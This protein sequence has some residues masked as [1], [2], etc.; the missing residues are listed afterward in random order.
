MLEELGEEP[1]TRLLSLFS[2][3][4]NPDVENFLKQK[5]IAFEKTHNARTRLILDEQGSILAYF[6]VS[7]KELVLE[8]AALNKSQVKRLDGFNKNAE[9]IRA[10][11]IGQ[12]GK[13]FSV[14][15]NRITLADIL[16]EIYSIIHDARELVGGR[17]IILECENNPA[18]IQLYRDHGFT[19]IETTDDDKTELRTMYIHI[20]NQ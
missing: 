17:V 16:A 9:R 15:N 20:A 1:T 13:N 3:P 18:L 10:F 6:S 11:L 19:L 12:L 4:R 7:F 8:S 2:C 14:Q 5:S